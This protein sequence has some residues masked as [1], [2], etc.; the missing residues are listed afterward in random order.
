MALGMLQASFAVGLPILGVVFP[1]SDLDLTTFGTLEDLESPRN[2][3]MPV[4]PLASQMSE[5]NLN[6]RSCKILFPL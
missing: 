6:Y 3:S 1:T 5:S 4:T 2:L